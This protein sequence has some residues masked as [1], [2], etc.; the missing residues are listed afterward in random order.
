M[1]QKADADYSEGIMVGYRWFVT[2]NVTPMYPFGYGMSYVPFKYSDAKAEI[3][4]KDISVTFTLTNQG[5]MT[6]DEVAQVYVS[7]PESKVERPAYELK[8][9]KRLTLKANETQSVTIDIP[10]EQLR[11]WNEFQHA[12]NVE[13]GKV[14]IH[15]GGSSVDLPLKTDVT[16]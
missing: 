4:G 5:R 12:W 7:R 13:K 8:G 14:T 9:F 16:L 2:K 1:E 15:I 3:I 11:H 10:I 6:A